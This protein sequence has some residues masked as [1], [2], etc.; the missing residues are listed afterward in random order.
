MQNMKKCE[1]NVIDLNKL[2][3]KFVETIIATK[4]DDNYFNVQNN[5][6]IIL[7]FEEKTNTIKMLTNCVNYKVKVQD[8]AQFLFI[9]QLF[10]GNVQNDEKKTFEIK[11]RFT[12]FD[13]FFV[14]EWFTKDVVYSFLIYDSTVLGVQNCCQEIGLPLI[15]KQFLY[16]IRV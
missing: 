2:D 16:I 15:L 5:K 3:N 14:M 8:I 4:K 10:I 6:T 9:M 13:L 12:K 11:K 7:I 1:C